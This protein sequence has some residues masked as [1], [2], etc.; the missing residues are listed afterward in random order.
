MIQV[1]IDRM[2]LSNMGFVLLLKGDDD[3]RSLPVFIGA[4]EAHAIALWI[5]KVEIPRPMTHDLL[6]NILDCAECRVHR[7]EVVELKKGTFYANIV[8]DIAGEETSVD[9]RPSDAI[10]LALRTGVAMYV[11]KSVM[12]QAGKVLDGPESTDSEVP[13]LER[14]RSDLETAIAEERY[15][16]A[17]EVRDRIREIERHSNHN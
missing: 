8:L 15:E 2:F 5:N 3:P 9:A 10:A 7:V 12:D 13:E 17:A 6:K 4:A 1:T 11:S 14:L 16:D